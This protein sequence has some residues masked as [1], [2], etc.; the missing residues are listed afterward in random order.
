MIFCSEWYN[1]F[2]FKNCN[3][4]FEIYLYLYLILIFFSLKLFFEVLR[5]FVIFVKRIIG[6][7]V[8][9]LKIVDRVVL[10][11]SLI[12]ESKKLGF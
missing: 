9:N 4:I 2:I 8:V 6:F 12:F 5:E 7:E 3:Y 10:E 1:I 11:S